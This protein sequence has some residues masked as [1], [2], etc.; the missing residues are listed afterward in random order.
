[1]V[2]SARPYAGAAQNISSET[3][4]HLPPSP[5]ALTVQANIEL[6]GMAD[7]TRM[8][9]VYLQGKHEDH[10][11]SWIETAVGPQKSVEWTVQCKID[12]VVKGA[13][14]AKHKSEAK[15]LAARNALIALGVRL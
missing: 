9:N 8:L 10:L 13:G 6:C 4:M 15:Q 11:L 3:S 14:L 2:V 7:Y 12:G 1:V 5:G